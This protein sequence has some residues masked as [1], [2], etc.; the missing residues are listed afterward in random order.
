LQARPERPAARRCEGS[1]HTLQG[2]FAAA[3][4]SP[5][6][7]RDWEDLDPVDGGERYYIQ[8]GFMP[9]D[10]VDEVIAAQIKSGQKPPAPAQQQNDGN[11]N[12]T[13]DMHVAWLQ[14]V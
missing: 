5:N 10:K 11:D 13:R 7:I 12:G 14:D 4:L 6:D 2:L 3:A 8:Q 1:W 9:L